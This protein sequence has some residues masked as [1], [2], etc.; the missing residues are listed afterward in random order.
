MTFLQDIFENPFAHRAL[1]QVHISLWIIENIKTVLIADEAHY[2][3]AGTKNRN[4]RRTFTALQ[5]LG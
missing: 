4:K 2:L 3:V 5:A 1:E